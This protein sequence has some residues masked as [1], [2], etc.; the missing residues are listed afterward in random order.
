[1]TLRFQLLPQ[2]F[3][4]VRLPPHAPVPPWAWGGAFSSV[5]RTAHEVSIVCENVPQDVDAERGWRC[6]ALEGP[7]PLT[8]IGIAAQF[9]AILAKS[10]V[11]VF[12]L[13]TFDTDYVLVREPDVERAIAALV[14]AGH[15]VA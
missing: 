7:I 6:L 13:S 3:A 2:R 14:A 1:M 4:L 10:S 15:R 8:E 9:T 11:S 5:T 12:L